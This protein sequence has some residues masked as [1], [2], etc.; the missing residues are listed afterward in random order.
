V[1]ADEDDVEDV[2]EGEDEVAT[3][4]R[5][6][7]LPAGPAVAARAEGRPGRGGSL[8]RAAVGALTGAVPPATPAGTIEVDGPNPLGNPARAPGAPAPTAA[9]SRVAAGVRATLISSGMETAARRR[10][11]GT[12]AS[13]TAQSSAHAR[14]CR[15]AGLPPTVALRR[16]GR[17]TGLCDV[18]AGAF[19]AGEPE[20]ATGAEAPVEGWAG[21]V[22]AASVLAAD[23]ADTECVGVLDG[24]TDEVGVFAATG[25]ATAAFVAVPVRRATGSETARTAAGAAPAAGNAGRAGARLTPTADSRWIDSAGRISPSA[26]RPRCP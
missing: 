9:S 10:M 2:V 19:A 17:S 16:T 7:V 21:A 18:K 23:D 13:V 5:L 24:A 25:A 12:P 26:R 1:R 8:T 14:L 22:L 4:D 3:L 20:A 6:T 11:A 15:W